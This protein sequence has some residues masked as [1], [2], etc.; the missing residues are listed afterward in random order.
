VPSGFVLRKRSASHW[1]LQRQWLDE[2]YPVEY[3]WHLSLDRKALRPGLWGLVYRFFAMKYP[4]HWIVQKNDRL[5]GMLTYMESGAYG[6]NL[7][8]ATH[9]D[10]DGQA[11][12]ALLIQSRKEIAC[13]RPLTLNYPAGLNEQD[14]TAA[15]FYEQ[16]TLIWMS[17]R[18]N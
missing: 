1:R 4:R 11:V 3:S 15:G 5:L 16:Q 17:F 14:I 8:L 9:P 6:D 13:R 10:T 12:Q 7:W 18:F 2:I